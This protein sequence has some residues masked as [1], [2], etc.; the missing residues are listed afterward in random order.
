MPKIALSLRSP[1]GAGEKVDALSENCT[2]EGDQLGYGCTI[3][4]SKS[5]ARRFGITTIACL[6]ASC[7]PLP[8][9]APDAQEAPPLQPWFSKISA[10]ASTRRSRI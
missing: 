3:S 9:A 5:E 10:V 6:P 1:R 4:I 2:T 7:K 8:P